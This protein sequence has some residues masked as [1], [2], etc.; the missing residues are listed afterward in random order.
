MKPL[1]NISPS[2]VE[3]YRMF[4]DGDMDGYVTKDRLV[5]YL[6]KEY[7][8][9]EA[10]SRGTAFHAMVENGPQRYVSEAEGRIIYRVYEPDMDMIHYFS[11]EDASYAQR[12]IDEHPGMS[13]EVK[14]HAY[15]ELP[16]WRVYSSM[17]VDG[18][19]GLRLE[20]L[21]TT[22]S[23]YA[24]KYEKYQ[25]SLQWRM[26]LMALPDCHA[27]D[28]HIIHWRT[29]RGRAWTEYN[30]YTY[31]PEP[32]MEAKVKG[33][34]QGLIAFCQANDL[35]ARLRPDWII[36]KENSFIANG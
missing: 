21:K 3:Q 34:M 16:E 22:S 4:Y 11:E 12:I 35:M 9:N 29:A 18:L 6:T 1:L 2:T 26:Y 5:E 17:R 7:E 33:Y 28:Y 27:V 25:P 30:Q 36:D 31:M 32:G 14:V 8:P 13:S 19:W 20:E 10:A 24:V 15:F 23:K